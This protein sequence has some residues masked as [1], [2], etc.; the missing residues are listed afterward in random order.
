MVSVVYCTREHKPEH[1]EHIRKAFGHPKVEVIEYVNSGE[2]LTKFYDRGLRE[3]EHDIVV[4]MHDDILINTKQVANKIVKIFEKNPEYGV[5]GLAGTK[6][7]PSSGMWWEDRRKM[8][9]RVEHTHEGKTW[10]SA[11]SKDLGNDVEEVVIVDGLFFSVHRGRIKEQFDLNVTGF[12]FYEVD[13]CFRNHLKGVKIGVHT[14]VR[15]NH[16]SIGQTNAEWEENRLAFAEKYKEHLPVTIKKTLRPNEKLNVLIGCLSFANLTG[17]ELYVYEL[18]KGLVKNGCEVSICSQ[19]GEPM[20]SKAKKLGIKLYGLNEPPHYKLGDGKWGVNTPQGV[21]TS[22]LNKLYKVSEDRFD[23]MHLNHKPITEFMLKLYPDTPTVCTIHSEVIDLE[24]PVISN[25]IEKYIAI[26]PEIKSHLVNSYGISETNVEVIYNP[27]DTDRFKPSKLV[28]NRKN[29]RIIFIGTIDYLR[30][31]AILDL[32]ETSAKEGNE[33]WLVGKENGVTV[34]DL[35]RESKS[36]FSH[37]IYFGVTD[38]VETLIKECD[39]TAGILL[40]RTTIEGWMCGKG[41]WIYDVDSYGNIIGKT[42]HAVPED[43]D[44][45]K[46][47][48]V[49]KRIIEVYKSTL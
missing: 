28:S 22:E 31:N 36:D 33:V 34:E 12:H 4:F 24:T 16:M 18:A 47:S 9:G 35:K 2:G 43:L 38:K 15:V 17:S 21:K 1:S 46:S 19:L 39:E 30:K 6:N 27:I 49:V 14:N 23:V 41:G 25:Q 20:I 10:L 40:G 42:F 29:K 11:Y 3:A 13:F 45:F 8:Y 32:I 26:R 48:G 44:K 7:M 37:V 5:L